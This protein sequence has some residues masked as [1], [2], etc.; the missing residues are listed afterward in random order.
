MK[1]YD[2]ITS[3]D[4]LNCNGVWYLG[5]RDVTVDSRDGVLNS[6][7]LTICRYDYTLIGG[8]CGT[9]TST[10]NGTT[11]SNG[12]PTNSVAANF[13][14]NYNSTGDLEACSATIATG[15]TVTFN[16]GHTFIVGDAVTVNG[17]GSL[18]INNN[19]ALR[20]TGEKI[21]VG[22]I[23]VKR[24]SAPMVRLDYTAWSSPVNGQQLQAFSPNTLSNRF[25]QYLYTGTTTPTAYQSVTATTNFIGGKGYMIRAANDWPLTATVFNGQ[26]TGVP[27]NGYYTQNI[28]K[29]YNLLGNP[30]ASPIDASKFL[31][32][33]STLVGALYF[34]THTSP[35]SGGVY[36][37]NNFASY[38]TLGGTA[39]AAGGAVPNGII[40]VGQG[41][42]INAFDSGSASFKNSQRV[43]ASASTQFFK[44]SNNSS[45]GNESEKHRIWLNLNDATNNYNQ[46]LLGYVNGATN[47][48]DQYIDAEVLNKEN[49]MLYNVIN[50]SEY[51]IQG[52]GLPFANTDEIALGLKATTAGTYTISLENVDGLFTSQNVY[53]KDNM[54]K[55][56]H[57]VKQAPYQF[58]TTEGVFNNRFKVV[59]TNSAL[60]NNSSI[61]DG[62]VIVFTQNEELKINASQEMSEVEVFDVLG[63]NIYYN[64]NVD[65]K[66]LNISSIANRNQAL[67]LKITFKS[68][69]S[70]TKKVIK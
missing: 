51:V 62:D 19:A 4:G 2:P 16:T 23:I 14:G 42:Y 37:V 29:G 44:T 52:K 57:N 28:G 5:I 27:F 58:V 41:F 26:F 65:A 9:T 50:D 70:V 1:P 13:T 54:T 66:V 3:F 48:I 46:I 12:I 64:S 67:L 39:S 43:N 34:W 68:G 8:P 49:T 25:Y 35:A 36:P 17:T 60:E 69:Q 32:D 31:T 45:T 21:N 15:V 20:Q 11:W 7:T 47:G 6:Y 22:N 24:N 40:Q 38:T 33:N 10:W 56:I 63:R 55:S 53:V 30:Y 61:S 59:F 18:V